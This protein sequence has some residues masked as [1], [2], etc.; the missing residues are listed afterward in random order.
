MPFSAYILE[1]TGSSSQQ[2][3]NPSTQSM[4]LRVSSPL[5]PHLNVRSHP[6]SMPR[7]QRGV[8]LVKKDEGRGEDSLEGKGE[9][10]SSECLLAT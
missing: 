8:N 7:V 6:G 5:P 3:G 4:M 1:V 9:G 2:A 10:E